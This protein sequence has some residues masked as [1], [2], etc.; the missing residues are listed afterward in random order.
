MQR[1]QQTRG[2]VL[3]Y[4]RV[5]YSPGVFAVSA[6]SKYSWPSLITI[7]VRLMHRYNIAYVKRKK[8]GRLGGKKETRRKGR[9]GKRRKKMKARKNRRRGCR[10]TVLHTTRGYLPRQRSARYA[11]RDTPAPNPQVSFPRMQT[12]PFLGL[13]VSFSISTFLTLSATARA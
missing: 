3:N 2:T 6:G 8:K 1:G 10:P 7:Y 9:E 5:E 11:S 12:R 13:L 4:A